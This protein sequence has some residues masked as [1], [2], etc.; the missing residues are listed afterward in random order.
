MVL[1]LLDS[2]SSFNREDFIR[3]CTNNFDTFHYFSIINQQYVDQFFMAKGED[4]KIAATFKAISTN[5]NLSLEKAS[6]TEKQ[7]IDEF[8][9]SRDEEEQ[10]RLVVF[11]PKKN[12]RAVAQENHKRDISTHR[13]IEV[14]GRGVV[15]SCRA[16][17][18]SA[19]AKNKSNWKMKLSVIAIIIGILGIIG[20]IIRKKIKQTGNHWDLEN[21]NIQLSLILPLIIFGMLLL[22][23]L[24]GL[25]FFGIIVK[26]QSVK[27][28]NKNATNLDQ[29]KVQEQLQK[30]RQKKD[31]VKTSFII[32][33]K[34]VHKEE[35]ELS[36][37]QIKTSIEMLLFKEEVTGKIFLQNK[38]ILEQFYRLIGWSFNNLGKTYQ[39]KALFKGNK[40][41][42][43]LAT[44]FF[45]LK[46]NL[47]SSSRER[48]DYRYEIEQREQGS[49]LIGKQHYSPQ[50]QTD[51]YLSPSDLKQQGLI[52]GPTGRGKSNFVSELLS[53]QQKYHP[54]IHF[55]LFDLKGEYVRFFGAD[56]STIVIIPGSEA[57]PLGLN[58]FQIDKGDI[59]SNK[60]FVKNLLSDYL[61]LSVQ[62]PELSPFMEDCVN[63]AID[64]TF[65]LPYNNRHLQSFV[66]MIGSVLEQHKKEGVRWA[67]STKVAL[68]ARFRELFSGWFKRVF[69]VEQSNFD[70]SLLEKYN[71]IIKMDHLLRDNDLNTVKLITNTIMNL[72]SRHGEE[73]HD[74][75]TKYPWL[76]CIFEEAQKIVPRI[77]KTDSSKLTAIESFMEIAR[78]YGVSSIAIGQNPLLISERFL[79]AGFIADFGTESRV[80]DNIIFTGEEDPS[81]T[82]SQE[83][84]RLRKPGMCF[85]KLTGHQRVLLEVNK[86]RPKRVLTIE[87]IKKLIARKPQYNFL[88]KKYQSEIV[89][90]YELEGEK[91]KIQAFKQLVLTE[92]KKDCPR[93]QCHLIDVVKNH[94][95]ALKK[96]TIKELK[97]MIQDGSFF[98]SAL[99]MVKDDRDTPCIILYYLIQLVTTGEL[100]MK[101]AL[102]I[103]RK[104][105]QELVYI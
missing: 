85:L 2:S 102:T 16:L 53:C 55:L 27:N 11:K 103:F 45:S 93:D 6:E 49:W 5:Y 60:R 24:V 104:G 46:T 66:Q 79:Q 71:V 30:E 47:P 31:Q 13:I 63:N 1:K 74:L 9:E 99:S 84:N 61:H 42:I 57:A 88:R 95:S 22:G 23:G 70:I 62:Q 10:T 32:I 72:L 12:N 14:A 67:D 51:F 39:K 21:S 20:T 96:I 54:E 64:K 101:E 19:V 50:I 65:E 92:C 82:A 98:I 73:L 4:N 41:P 90:E 40:I 97:R 36:C 86:F 69:G 100:S 26:K 43:Q 25:L 75:N 38:S 81:A 29:Q 80:L 18:W 105:K 68:K 77:Q 59:D 91:G 52:C 78:A 83:K 89:S 8:F 33:V 94:Q 7:Q 87:Q 37:Q 15:G 58:I 56:S 34:G 17:T 28:E 48:E 3:A 35:V 76:L 44:I